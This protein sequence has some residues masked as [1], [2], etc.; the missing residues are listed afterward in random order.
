[1][2]GQK[3]EV[4]ADPVGAKVVFSGHEV[5]DQL[6]VAVKKLGEGAGRTAAA[7][8]AGVVLNSA[9]DVA[10]T[11]TTGQD[12]TSFPA[13]PTIIES[14]NGPEVVTAVNPGV[15]L[16]L[17][18]DEARLGTTVGKVDPASVRIMTRE[19]PG[20]P[21]VELPSYYDKASGKVRGESDHLSQFVVIGTPF[22][23]PAGPRVVLD[24]DDDIAVTTGPGG[25]MTELPQNVRLANEVAAVM[26]TT[27]KADVLVTRPTATPRFISPQTRAAMAAAHNP[28]LTV[29]L[30]FDALFGHPWGVAADGGTKVY[31]RGGPDDNAVT[32]S[33]VAQMPGYTGRPAEQ[34]AAGATTPLPYLDLGSLPGAVTH[35]EAL[36]IDHN[37]DRPVIDSGFASITNGVFTG[38]GKYLESKGFNCTNPATGGWPAKPSAA[39]LAKWRNLGFHNYQAY[40]AEPVSFTTG[41]LIEKFPLFTLTGPGNQNLDLSLVYNSQDG[42]FTRTGAGVSFE[43]GARVQRFDDGSVLAVRG[44]GASYVF[45]GNGA[46]GF[47]AEAGTVNTLSDAGNGQLLL[48][49]PDGET[50]LFDT[51]DVEG[52]GELVRQ[53]DRQGNSTTLAYGPGTAETQF[54]PL[55]SIT[56]TAGQTVLVGSDVLGRIT[57]F[58]HPDGRVW[59]LA[60]DAVGNLTVITEPDGRTRSFTY[61]GVHQ[62]ITATDPLGIL[63][64]R[65][66]YDAAGRVV[67]QWDAEGSERV[68]TYDDAAKT[69]TYTDNEGNTTVYTRDDSYRVTRIRDAAGG[70]QDF[71]YDGNNQVTGYTNQNGKSTTYA[72]DAAGHLISTT[73]ADGTVTSRTYTPAGDLASTT[74][75]GGPGGSARTT[76]FDSDTRGLPITVHLPDGTTIKNAFDARGN[77]TASTDQLGHTTGYG[78]D[79]HGNLTTVADPLGRTSTFDYDV[80]NRVTAATDPRGNTTSYAWDTADRLVTQKD[81]AGGVTTLS[82]DG[83]NHLT[84]T[85]DPTGAVTKYAWDVLFRVTSVTNPDGGKTTY[86]YNR[87][88]ELTRITDPLGGETLFELDPLYRITKTIDP[89]GG[90]WSR[91]WDRAGNLVTT[92]D[93]ENGIITTGYDALNRVTSTTNPT[94]AK[95]VY[96]LDGVGRTA[97]VTDPVG[98]T[99]RFEYDVMDRL[100]KTTDQSGN[101]STTSYDKAGNPV[102]VT[103]RRG[104]E[105]KRTFD[106]AGQ[107]TSTADPTGAGSSF[108]YDAN[109][110]RIT[111]TDPLRRVTTTVYDVM[112]RPVSVRNPAGETT[113]TSYDHAGRVIS[114]TDGDGDAWTRSY[115]IAGNLVKTVDPDGVVSS[116]GWDVAR[117]QT[118]MTEGSGTVTAYSWDKA[119]Q[120]TAVTQNH[121]AGKE[122]DADTNVTTSY[123]Y[124]PAGYLAEVT[125]PN[126]NTTKF[127]H[128]KAGRTTAETNPAG[129]KLEYEYDG[130]GL[131]T[132]QKDANGTTTTN[133]Y[134][135]TEELAAVAY[136]TG[137]KI[138]YGY[139]AEQAMITMEDAIGASAWTYD[140][141]GALKSQTDALGKKLFY[142]YDPAGQMT[143]LTLPA[144]ATT[145]ATTGNT[146]GQPTVNKPIGISY[147]YDS[148]GRVMSLASPWGS[149]D[150]GYTPAGNTAV[151]TRSNGVKTTTEYTPANRTETITHATT[152]PAAATA[153]VATGAVPGFAPKTKPVQHDAMGCT[154]ATSYLANRA[155]P[156]HGATGTNCVKTA[157]YL[158]RRTLPTKEAGIA[159][160]ESLTL[161]YTYDKNGNTA[162]RTRKNGATPTSNT[163][164]TETRDYTYD[165]L[166][167]L[168]GSTSNTG[169]KNT[170]KFDRNGNRTS[171]TT[172]D[173]PSTT[174][175]GDPLNVAAVFDN[176]DEPTKETRTGSGTGQ[177]GAVTTSYGY[178]A[179]G[180]RIRVAVAGGPTTTYSYTPDNQTQSVTR[181]GIES[182]YK[183]DG[184]G[185]NLT[186]TDT[187]NYGTHET[188]TAFKGLTPIQNTDSHGTANLIP[189]NLGHVALQTG[190]TTVED[191]W[192]LLDR[193][194]ST[195]AQTTNILGAGTIDQL[196]EYSDYGVQ[197]Y[198]TTGWDADPNYTGQPTNTTHATYRYHARTLDPSTGTWTG[199]DKWRGLLNAP[200]T[201]NRYAYTLNNP[202]TLIDNLGNDPVRVIGGISYDYLPASESWEPIPGSTPVVLPVPPLP[203][204]S[205]RRPDYTPPTGDSYFNRILQQAAAYTPARASTSQISATHAA[206]NCASD[207]KVGMSPEQLAINEAC[208]NALAEAKLQ[209]KPEWVQD[210]VHGNQA[211]A[212]KATPVVALGIAGGLGSAG[213]SKAETGSIAN[214]FE[215]GYIYHP[216]IRA[217]GVEDPRAHNFPYSFDDVILRSNPM[218]QADG[219]Y[220]YRIPGEINGKAGVYEIALNPDSGIIFHRTWRS[221]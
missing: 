173:N 82:Y 212:E 85:T 186:N 153:A 163:P 138:S 13:D 96:A 216:R 91:T 71:S 20:E 104:Q 22:T 3:S 66:E 127:S 158:A 114:S 68:F 205:I 134:T 204:Y 72:F 24:P 87:E 45:T 46:G 213:A 73:A 44:D 159:A 12:M 219:S 90:Q 57:S 211:F 15:S 175:A 209:T 35:L 42:R 145:P 111:V 147:S 206:L 113:T 143:T 122:E 179:N 149:M 34:A 171:W 101:T 21:W 43:L 10:A 201:L 190:T 63:Y 202:T 128:D 106:A 119:S 65:N 11:D 199:Q 188:S 102:A 165:L 52:I 84:S 164:V 99:R 61:D 50:W 2:P 33:L 142:D 177:P 48:A 182:T 39:E 136:S 54:L 47:T 155:L 121:V 56:D 144:G 152:K 31:T 107:L 6:N 78:Y 203:P 139:D 93:P 126:G 100:V 181:S 38:L 174:T 167:R 172:N 59:R 74:D 41:N 95:T 193:L 154:T 23:P 192:A 37:F 187:T 51:S 29:T 146:A 109:G 9:V 25:D 221:E 196:A 110:N 115:D 162:S 183:Y 83:N 180:N 105:W 156:E 130:R 198:G 16:E 207:V 160:G 120:L 49:S 150:Y 189:D 191:R 88:D 132:K 168:T 112:N 1:M 86:S 125:N 178:D 69:T 184:L 185:R 151:V 217:R 94:G 133:T 8:T 194:G 176:I 169:V 80:A 131:L 210:L 220:L 161:S 62:L 28:D 170:Y 64:L 18:V 19:K 79:V 197:G 75:A 218:T 32:T 5:K 116:Y 148:A 60:Y 129:K 98:G 81:T 157:D 76:S 215:H 140:A 103:D 40:G 58:T 36:Y 135:P 214:V 55:S 30:A 67:K 195:I 4:S 89:L 208:G 27:C 92:T 137:Q 124:S 17:A 26:R 70:T 166:N 118:S 200:Q 7:E 117:N 97:V 141:R 77:L 53:S 123:A 108:G 14:Q